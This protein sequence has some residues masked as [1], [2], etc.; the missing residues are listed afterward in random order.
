[1][2]LLVMIVLGPT[3][4]SAGLEVVEPHTKVLLVMSTLY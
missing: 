1:M 2:R 3:V 4:R